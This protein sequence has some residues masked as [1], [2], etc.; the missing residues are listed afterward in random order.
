MDA[1]HSEEQ[2]QHLHPLEEV[3]LTW[4][5]SR[6]ELDAVKAICH[7][8]MDS[9]RLELL[10]PRMPPLLPD[11]LKDIAGELSVF[12]AANSA[13]QINQVL[14]IPRETFRVP[15]QLVKIS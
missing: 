7:Q 4:S 13:D 3:A 14:E 6:K 5:A 15:R 9:T 11:Q 2:K 12:L 8:M 1:A 10:D